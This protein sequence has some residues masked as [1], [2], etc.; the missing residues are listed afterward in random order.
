MKIKTSMV[1]SA[2]LITSLLASAYALSAP[3][4]SAPC[5]D[6]ARGPNPTVASLKSRSGPF[7][8][9]KFSVSGYL[10]GF[11]DSTVHYPTNA[12]GRMGAIA[13]I[14]GYLSYENSIEW[15]GPRLASHGFVVMT[16]NTNTIYDQ[17]D[18]RQDR[19]RAPGRHRLVDGRRWLAQARDRT[20]AQRNYPA[21]A[22][23]RWAQQFQHLQDA[24]DDSG[25]RG[26]CSGAG[27]GACLAV[28]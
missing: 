24:D 25:V 3:G 18:C 15:W 22:V 21:G 17:P 26:R 5:T 28:L 20:F 19:Q 6:C 16:M 23:L 14:P 12:S 8:V 13:V 4:P 27:G 7:S 10:K 9:A 2:L 11:G 1:R